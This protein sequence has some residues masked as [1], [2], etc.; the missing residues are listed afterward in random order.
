MPH[1]IGN[2][3][4]LL[5]AALT[6]FI[7]HCGATAYAQAQPQTVSI[8]I[9]RHAETD[10]TQPTVPLSVAG[11][12]RADL[13]A[14]TLNGV[15]FSHLFATH[16]TRARQMLV[17]IAAK[18]GL[19][20]VQL[21]VPG[22]VLDGQPVTDLTSRRAP[23]EPIAEAL[24]KLPPGSVAL[25]ALNSENIYAILNRLGVPVAEPGKSCMTG[26]MCVPCLDNKCFPNEFDRLWHL[27]LE[28]GRA[29]PLAYVELR[30]GVGLRPAER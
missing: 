4:A 3:R 27:V 19:Q 24:L 13:L 15:T 9:V 17:A 21:P 1:R 7:A 11:R 16:T 10:G 20:I 22:T 29:T 8:F 23:I 18:E 30:Y 25:V 28:P 2:H 14:P 5:I 6:G 12:Q 26:H